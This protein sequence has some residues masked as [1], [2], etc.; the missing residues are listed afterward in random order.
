M[1]KL[2]IRFKKWNQNRKLKNAIKKAD[3]MAKKS[4]AKFLVLYYKGKMLVKSK[5]QLK[6]M[7][8]DGVFVKGFSIQKAEEIALYITNK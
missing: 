6:K 3:W 8:K 7:I 5:Q 1:V 2:I 4:R